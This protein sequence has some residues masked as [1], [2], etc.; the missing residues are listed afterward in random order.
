MTHKK[1]VLKIFGVYLL[2]EN[3]I[4]ARVLGPV[5]SVVSKRVWELIRRRESAEAFY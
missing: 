5:T 1:K 3:T 4:I 2:L